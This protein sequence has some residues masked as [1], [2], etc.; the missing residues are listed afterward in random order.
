MIIDTKQIYNFVTGTDETMYSVG[1]KIGLT[2][3]ALTKFRNDPET[4]KKAKLETLMKLQN[5]INL[6]DEYMTRQEI[7]ED[8][9]DKIGWLYTE[10]VV[11][12]GTVEYRNIEDSGEYDDEAI[13]IINLTPEYWRD[14]LEEWGIEDTENADEDT[15]DDF[16]ADVLEDY[17]N[18]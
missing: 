1:Q 3:S 15:R 10:A 4:L 11:F 5:Y 13:A 16:I 14:T 12:D 7:L 8:I 17:L 9:F 6:G 18:N 2:R